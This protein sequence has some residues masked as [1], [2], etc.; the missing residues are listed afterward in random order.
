MVDVK[1]KWLAYELYVHSIVFLSL[2]ETDFFGA[3]L[4]GQD[5]VRRM[6]GSVVS[7]QFLGFTASQL[8]PDRLRLQIGQ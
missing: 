1:Q 6:T 4:M 7:L 5:G 2:V 3:L 8:D